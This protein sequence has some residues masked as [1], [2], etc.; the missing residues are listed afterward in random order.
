[1]IPSMRKHCMICDMD[2]PADQQLSAI[3]ACAHVFCEACSSN[4][5]TYK[6]NAF[7]DIR[8]PMEGCGQPLDKTTQAFQSLAQELKRKCEKLDRFEQIRKNPKIKLC[9]EKNCEG[10]FDTGS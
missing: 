3:A 9:T 7:E 8:C 1:M 2:V 5:L 4:Y 10:T 6:I